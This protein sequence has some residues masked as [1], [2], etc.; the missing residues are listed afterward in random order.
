V[1]KSGNLFKVFCINS[2]SNQAH[3]A[4]N[5]VY[6]PK[7]SAS[8]KVAGSLDQGMS[9]HEHLQLCDLLR[10]LVKP[11]EE[12][13]RKCCHKCFLNLFSPHLVQRLMPQLP[14]AMGDL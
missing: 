11:V 9:D 14:E 10:P 4:S 3:Q 6:E 5:V 12:L 13:I 8:S 1:D 2:A 7:T